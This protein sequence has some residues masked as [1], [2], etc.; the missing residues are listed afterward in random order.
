MKEQYF[1]EE[2]I[3]MESKQMLDKIKSFSRKQLF[4]PSKSA[5]LIL[6]MQRYFLDP[7][8][9]AFIPSAPIILP[10]IKMLAKLFEDRNLPVFTTRHL[11]SD[12]NAK[13]MKTWWRDMIREDNPMSE[14]IS[15]FSSYT[16]IVKHQY[17]AF[18]NTSL[19]ENLKERKVEQIVVT[20]VMTHLCVESTIRSAFIR[21]FTVFLPIDGTATYSKDFHLSSILNLSHG[22]A[23][24]TLTKDLEEILEGYTN[25]ET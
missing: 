8:S 12:D 18:Y 7:K 19:E 2:T 11:N 13:L 15:D 5:L 21:G 3:E 24:P 1:T 9:H 16:M 22:F 4:K 20:G 6:D 10:R 14:I 23:I 25:G 17:D